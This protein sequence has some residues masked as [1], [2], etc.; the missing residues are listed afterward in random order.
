MGRSVGHFSHMELH[1][2]G[3]FIPC[4]MTGTKQGR[5]TLLLPVGSLGVL[6]AQVSSVFAIRAS[7]CAGKWSG[8]G[9]EHQHSPGVCN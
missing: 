7:P 1:F 6:S 4:L 9:E 8:E 5:D 2:S 3:S